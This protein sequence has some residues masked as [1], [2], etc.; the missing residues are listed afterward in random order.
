VAQALASGGLD[1]ATVT[2]DWPAAVQ[3]IGQQKL[4][5]GMALEESTMEVV[6]GRLILT[7]NKLF[8]QQ[9]VARTQDFIGQFLKARWNIM[10]QIELKLIPQTSA[11]TPPRSMSAPVATSTLLAESAEANNDDIEEIPADQAAPA[12]QNLLKDFPGT[13]KRVKKSE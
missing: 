2:A 7:F 10:P 12:V 1:P 6:S 3:E 8:N 11:P 4:S 5:V 13:L 9:T